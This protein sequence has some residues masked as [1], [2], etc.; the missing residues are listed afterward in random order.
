MAAIGESIISVFS[1][2]FVS[3]TKE[4]RETETVAKYISFISLS[5]VTVFFTG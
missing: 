3:D 5:L 1:L 2:Y 4:P